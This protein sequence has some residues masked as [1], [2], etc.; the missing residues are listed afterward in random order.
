MG[1]PSLP[2]RQSKAPKPKPGARNS[3]YVWVW[4]VGGLLGAEVTSVS[5]ALEGCTLGTRGARSNQGDTLALEAISLGKLMIDVDCSMRQLYKL[6]CSCTR[7]DL[8]V[9]CTLLRAYGAP[10]RHFHYCHL[11]TKQCHGSL[12]FMMSCRNIGIEPEDEPL[13]YNHMYKV[14]RCKRSLV[15]R[16]FR[17]RDHLGMQAVDQTQMPP[18]STIIG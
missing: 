2:S 6:P 1:S 7:P 5:I 8:D 10:C 18:L 13:K 17:I 9:A 12:M 11:A 4:Y 14:L 16:I 15:F 3:S